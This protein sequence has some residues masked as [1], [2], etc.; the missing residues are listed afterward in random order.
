MPSAPLPDEGEPMTA[1]ELQVLELISQGLTD[2]AIGR[3]LHITQA[4]VNSHTRRLY[5][6]LG[7][8]Q[9]AHAV[10]I[11]YEQGLL[12]PTSTAEEQPAPSPDA[13]PDRVRT[14]VRG[15]VAAALLHVARQVDIHRAWANRQ[16]TL[17]DC[18]PCCDCPCHRGSGE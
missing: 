11:A 8:R 6:K 10:A 14:T 1:R 13:T 15:T 4:T 17:T 9:R 2:A 12:R 3:A 5:A 7:V 18:A 16:K